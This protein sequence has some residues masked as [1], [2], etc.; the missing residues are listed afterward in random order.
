MPKKKTA[1]RQRKRG[2]QLNVG[3]TEKEARAARAWGKAFKMTP[4]ALIRRIVT[5]WAKCQ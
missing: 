4:Q 2:F 5:Q 3:L 1:P